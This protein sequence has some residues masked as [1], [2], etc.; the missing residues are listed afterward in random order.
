MLM[1][2]MRSHVWLCAL[3]ESLKNGSCIVSVAYS[4]VAHV[5]PSCA[6]QS[7]MMHSV[8]CNIVWLHQDS[9]TRCPVG[10]PGM[11]EQPQNT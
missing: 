6:T 7:H 4:S 3:T 2:L 1:G 11:V 10:V 9:P 5:H 8:T